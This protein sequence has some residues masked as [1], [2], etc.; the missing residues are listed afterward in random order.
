MY[1]IFDDLL[2]GERASCVQK[3][4][5]TSSFFHLALQVTNTNGKFFDYSP[6]NLEYLKSLNATRLDLI[7]YPDA[8]FGPRQTEVSVMAD[9]ILALSKIAP[10]DTTWVLIDARGN[11]W[12]KT[13]GIHTNFL[14]ELI[15]AL[16]AR[17]IK[18][19]FAVYNNRE[20]NSI[21]GTDF[22]IYS[23]YPLVYQQKTFYGF[24]GWTK[25]NF[26]LYTDFDSLCQMKTKSY[27][28]K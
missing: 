26:L 14:K 2:Q 20:W 8:S 7:F 16:K 6:R 11:N 17:N 3:R 19:G 15:D 10:M 27:S 18:F 28:P 4:I 5:Q 9:S 13:F 21:F 23:D 22:K 24:G 1:H 12:K 25:P